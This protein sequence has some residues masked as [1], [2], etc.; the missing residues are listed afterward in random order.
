M[1]VTSLAG[2]LPAASSCGDSRA[3]S[4]TNIVPNRPVVLMVKPFGWTVWASRSAATP[5]RLWNPDSSDSER[6][7]VPPVQQFHE[8]VNGL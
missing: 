1:R 5:G 2:G 7:E 4:T 3:R 6:P 8:A